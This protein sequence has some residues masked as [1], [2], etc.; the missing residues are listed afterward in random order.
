MAIIRAYWFAPNRTEMLIAISRPG[1][2]SRMSTNRMTTV[3]TQPPKAPATTPNVMPTITPSTVA[4]TPI[5]SDCREPQINR[6]SRSRP[7]LSTPSGN[8]SWLPGM[9]LGRISL[10]SVWASGSR[11]ASSG[12]NAATTRKTTTMTAPRMATGSRRSRRNALL[13]S[14]TP[15]SPSGTWPVRAAS[16]SIRRRL[17]SPRAVT[18]PPFGHTRWSSDAHSR[19]EQTVGDVDQQ[20]HQHVDD[21]QHEDEPLQEGVVAGEQRVP[22]GG[23]HPAEREHRLGEHRTGEQQ[24]GLQADRRRH[25]QQ[26]VL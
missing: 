24:A 8:P 21:R 1:I 10:S 3:S 7:R 6:D 25:R 4:L 16:S 15:P 12:A 19:V 14:E 13:V 26:S 23:A 18:I 9:W 22:Q 20:V 11:A 17:T 5:I 2:D